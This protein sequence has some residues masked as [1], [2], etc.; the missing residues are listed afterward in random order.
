MGIR[1]SAFV[2]IGSL[3]MVRRPR[4][5]NVLQFGT[6]K[7]DITPPTGTPLTCRQNLGDDDATNDAP[8]NPALYN[9]TPGYREIFQGN[10]AKPRLS[11][12]VGVN[13]VSPFGPFR[14]DIAKA[15]MKQEGDDP[16]LFSFNVGTSF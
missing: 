10:S 16:K 6:L 9:I 8:C 2:D 11:I 13:W 5:D 14:I 15:L 4:L 1:P 3:W 12:G 7:A